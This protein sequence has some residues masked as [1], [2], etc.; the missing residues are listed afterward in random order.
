MGCWCPFFLFDKLALVVLFLSIGLVA[1]SGICTMFFNDPCSPNVARSNLVSSFVSAGPCAAI[2][3]AAL[4]W[5]IVIQLNPLILIHILLTLTCVGVSILSSYLNYEAIKNNDELALFV[6]KGDK[7]Y[8]LVWNGKDMEY[9]PPIEGDETFLE[10]PPMP[11]EYGLSLIHIS[12]PTRPLY[13]SYAVFCLKK[14]KKKTE[15]K[16]SINS[17]RE[18]KTK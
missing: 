6:N 7:K 14:K 5:M 15:E 17:N 8:Y 13:I 9:Y 10:E 12:E 1:T 16:K 18:K 4:A 3:L 2:N 11:K